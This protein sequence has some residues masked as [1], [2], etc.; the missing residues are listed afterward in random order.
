MIGSVV[1]LLCALWREDNS[2]AV[3]QVERFLRSIKLNVTIINVILNPEICCLQA[4]NYQQNFQANVKSLKK[5]YYHSSK[6]VCVSHALYTSKI[7]E[8]VLELT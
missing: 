8:N 1:C 6:C 3:H 7:S 5:I 2:F 4:E